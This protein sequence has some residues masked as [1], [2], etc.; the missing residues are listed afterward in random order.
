MHRARGASY[1]PAAVASA[2]ADPLTPAPPSRSTSLRTQLCELGS[3]ASYLRAAEDG[4]MNT[5][6]GLRHGLA[7]GV[8]SGLRY[9]H[10]ELAEPLIHRDIKPDNILVDKAHMAKL[11]DFG[12]STHFSRKE[13]KDQVEGEDGD[14][15]ALTMTMVGTRVYCA[16]EA[17][18]CGCCRCGC[19]WHTRSTRYS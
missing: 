4:S 15:T 1:L 6:E 7:F 18:A 2:P 14:G 8:A 9:L 17:S 16:P 19:C 12:E 11:A 5:W 3:F 10:H 13:A